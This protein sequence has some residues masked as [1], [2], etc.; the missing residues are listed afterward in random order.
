MTT[1]TTVA[2]K[3]RDLYAEALSR[4]EDARRH[5]NIHPEVFE[6]LRRP[7]AILMVSVPVRMDDGTLQV[8][9]GYRVRHDD[10][11]GPSKGGIRFHPQVD[12]SEV[13][14]LAL[15]MTCKCA[16]VGIPYGGAKGG[17]SV[18]PKK[19]SPME[20]E[21]LS[22]SY[23]QQIADFIGPDVDIP[24]PDVYTTPRIMAWMADEYAKITRAKSPAVITGKPIAAGGSLGRDDATGRGAYYCVKE[25]ERI[26][27]WTPGK[28]KVAVQGFGNAG[29]HF[30]ALLA[31]DGYSVVAISDSVGG[32][33]CPTGIDVKAAI[34]A[35]NGGHTVPHLARDA[36][37]T[38]GSPCKTITNAELLTLD[39][40]ILAPAALENQ[41]TIDNAAQV[42]AKVVVE[43]ANG[44]TTSSADKILHQRGV[45]VIPDILANA[46]G[47][48]VSYFEW[49]QN[50]IGMAWEVEEVHNKLRT[51]MARE[52]TAVLQ[53]AQRI[54][55][56]T[57]TAAYAH[58]LDR[59]GEAIEAQGTAAFF[60]SGANGDEA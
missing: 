55:T 60:A 30:A 41:I 59:L 31:A 40:D 53:R 50:R 38:R 27:G 52:M 47:V 48:T 26:R 46:G 24:A 22:R 56:D 44:P 36:A 54:G 20:L 13:K 5:C 33:H 43:L 6:R 15:W 1:D 7:K 49:V 18:D 29:Q 2:I 25:L 51:V 8:F 17:I 32:L 37:V 42:K 4:L 45:V 11:R 58:A 3:Q 35:K 12:L 19:L 10:S 21:R 9:E 34:A 14:A 23:V 28:T 57:R 16:V 39:V